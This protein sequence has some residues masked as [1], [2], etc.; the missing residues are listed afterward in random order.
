MND[1]MLDIETLGTRAD[2]VILSIG[3]VKFDPYGDALDIDGG[4][5]ASV[6]IDS[7]HEA[8]RRDIS[9]ETLIWWLAQDNEARRVFVEPK[10][11]L[12]CALEDL[13][14]YFSHRDYQVWSN[15]AD[16]DLAMLAHAYAAFGIALPWQYTNTNCFRTI[17]KL[18]FARDVPKI[19]QA[20]KHHA[21]ADSVYQAR[22]LQRYCR[23]LAAATRPG[24]AA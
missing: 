7:N 16:F 5:Y 18:P 17:K 24:E 1:I 4:F 11:T 13:A 22:Q 14:F 12:R 10:T 19:L 2:S 9:E 23:A 15:G 6:S 20:D 8:G 21:R 3:A